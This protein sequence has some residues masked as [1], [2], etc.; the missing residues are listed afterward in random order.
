MA[1]R[2]TPMA[3]AT[4][5]ATSNAAALLEP[6]APPLPGRGRPLRLHPALLLGALLLLTA[7]FW[8]AV[9]GLALAV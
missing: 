1:E 6:T 2:T 7:A 5:N 9:V 3:G 4:S 8:T